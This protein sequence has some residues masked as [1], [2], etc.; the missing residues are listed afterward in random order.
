MGGIWRVLEILATDSIEC[1]ILITYGWF[2]WSSEG[3]MLTRMQIMNQVQEAAFGSKVPKGS[4]IR[5]CMCYTQQKICVN[6]VHI[7]TLCGR[8]TW[9]V[10]KEISMQFSVQGMAHAMLVPFKSVQK[11]HVKSVRVHSKGLTYK[12]EVK[13]RMISQ[14]LSLKITQELYIKMG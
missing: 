1:Y 10:V 2:W 7:L 3:R 8:L 14:R 4:W 13:K 6:L 5:G 11:H 9:S 12:V